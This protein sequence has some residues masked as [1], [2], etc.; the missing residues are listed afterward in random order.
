MF[1]IDQYQLPVIICI[2]TLLAVLVIAYCIPR[3]LPCNE[4]HTKNIPAIEISVTQFRPKALIQ[5]NR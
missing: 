4:N 5:N 3:L 1:G 2:V